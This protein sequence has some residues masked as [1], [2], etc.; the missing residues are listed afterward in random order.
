MLIVHLLCKNGHHETW[1]SQPFV[2]DR[3]LGNLRLAC[4]M[5][6]SGL[7]FE[8]VSEFLRFSQ[9]T[10]ISNDTFYEIQRTILQPVINEFWQ[11]DNNRVIEKAKREN[12]VKLSGDGQCDSP[13]HSAKYGIYSFLNQSTNEIVSFRLTQVT[14]AGN[15]NAM[16][17]FGMIKNLEYLRS[18]DVNVKQITIDRHISCRKYI[19]EKETTIELQF[20]VWH[21]SKSIKK[22]LC[23]LAKKK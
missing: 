2:R 11:L 17:K 18:R 22:K 4:G 6:L 14:E 5:V 16:E 20:D 21:F 12:G 7:R 9:V 1:H 8:S 23:A 3:A 10:F 19:A 13:G 15:S